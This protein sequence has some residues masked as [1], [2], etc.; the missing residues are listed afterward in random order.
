MENPSPENDLRNQIP[1][2]PKNW[3]V[4]SILVTAF[5]C[6]PFGIIGI[7][8]AAEVNSKWATGDYAGAA[9]SAARARKW[10]LIGFTLG[11]FVIGSLL[12]INV[13]LFIK[14]N[15]GK[16]Q[17]HQTTEQVSDDSTLISDLNTK[18]QEA[19]VNI[20]SYKGQNV[21]LDSIVAEKEKVLLD[22]KDN[23]S[24]GQNKSKI[25]RSEYDK[26]VANMNSIVNDLQT[27]I[28][29]LQQQDNMLIT[30]NDS[31]G[32]SLAQQ[33][34]TTSQQN[35]K[36]TSH[37]TAPVT[38]LLKPTSISITGVRTKSSGTEE[39]TDNAKQVERLKVC[40]D[41]PEN[42]GT[43]DGEKTFYI[44]IIGPDG[45]TLATEST[46]SGVIKDARTA[47]PIQYSTATMINY[48]K[49]AMNACAAWQQAA[50]FGKGIYL[51]NIY[52]DGYLVGTG[53]LEL[54]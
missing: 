31:L 27:Q 4:E 30:K 46:G 10:V 8:N 35:F 9:E 12:L 17:S 24:S 3:L 53:K 34:I 21:Q 16:P 22:F 33:M 50:P 41:I 37:K 7:I 38:S 20:E 32:N 6:L 48:E 43:D 40:W 26:K 45:M 23:Y 51:V 2:R 54:K 44:R 14:Y 47:S 25:S 39:Q 42:A 5:C 29:Q 1:P 28:T 36:A 15:Q 52:E 18:Y 13:Y 19:L 49:K 11:L